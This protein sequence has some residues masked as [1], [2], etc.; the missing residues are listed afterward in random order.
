MPPYALKWLWRGMLI[1]ED[2]MDYPRRHVDAARR[3]W[4]RSPVGWGSIRPGVQDSTVTVSVGGL[5]AS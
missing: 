1:T 2:V 4:G 3:G 5:G